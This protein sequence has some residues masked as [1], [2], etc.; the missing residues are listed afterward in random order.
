VAFTEEAV[1]H[2]SLIDAC[3]SNMSLNVAEF[4]I[5]SRV[6]VRHGHRLR[7]SEMLRGGFLPHFN[8]DRRSNS[9]GRFFGSISLAEFWRWGSSQSRRSRDVVGEDIIVEVHG[10]GIVQT[11]LI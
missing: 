2:A 7:G 6:V 9:V 8:G 10:I 1:T 4:F 3:F 11:I 5:T